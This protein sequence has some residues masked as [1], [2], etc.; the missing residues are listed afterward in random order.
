MR[1]A[2]YR[3]ISTEEQSDFSLSAQEAKCLVYIDEQQW[4]HVKTYTDEGVSGAKESRPA[5]DQLRH[6]AKLKRFDV[7]LVHDLSRLARGMRIQE[8]ILHEFMNLRVRL[9]ALKD[10]F[11]SANPQSMLM[12][13]FMGIINQQYRDNLRWHTQKG[14]Q[15]KAARGH[16][17]GTVPWGYRALDKNTIAPDDNAQYIRQIFTLYATGQYSLSALADHINELQTRHCTRDFIR[18]VLSSRAYLGYVHCGKEYQGNHEPLVTEDVWQACQAIRNE[19][20]GE[21]RIMQKPKATIKGLIM[22]IISCER[23][24]AAMWQ[25]VNSN[26]GK[27][28]PIYYYRCSGNSRRTCNAPLSRMTKVDQMVLDMLAS[29]MLDD[30]QIQR[31]MEGLRQRHPTPQPAI[32]HANIQARIDRLTL[33]WSHGNLSDAVYNRE[34][35][36]LKAR[37]DEQPK[38]PQQIDIAKA[39]AYLR[40][41]PML[42]NA[43]GLQEQRRIVQELL[44]KVVVREG[45][46]VRIKP[47]AAFAP[48]FPQQFDVVFGAGDETRTRNH[49]LGRQMRYHCATPASVVL[50]PI[51]P[52]VSEFVKSDEC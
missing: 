52:E 31:V 16:W 42:L 50:A 25:H 51:M 38:Q 43:V 35:A 40:N 21:R 37:F 6:D 12:A 8:N 1:I 11:D 48:L 15:E 14:L 20:S 36:K 32:D 5:L 29:F 39:A 24:G 34:V 13:Q 28:T 27:A 23:C 17:V 45:L 26:M 41:V 47:T 19:R 18:A 22:S 10:G 30:N 2:I 9:I 33:A 46:V 3:R 44:V 49:L 7:I 4:T